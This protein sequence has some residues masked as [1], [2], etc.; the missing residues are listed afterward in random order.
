[1]KSLKEILSGIPKEVLEYLESNT[2]LAKIAIN[3]YKSDFK[4]NVIY[5]LIGFTLSLIPTIVSS[6]SEQQEKELLIKQFVV[7][8]TSYDNLTKE[9]YQMHF[10][11]D[12]LK[13]KL[14]SLKQ[15]K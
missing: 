5:I 15:Q 10:E 11:N 3:S 14:N 1:M 13:N 12:S 2:E 7:I 4:Y 9:L 8:N 6:K